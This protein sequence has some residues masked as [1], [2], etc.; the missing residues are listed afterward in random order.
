[1]H[2]RS[3]HYGGVSYIQL[4]EEVGLLYTVVGGSRVIVYS[5]SERQGHCIQLWEEG[6]LLYTFVVRGRVIVY[7]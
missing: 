2:H 4:E 3:M 6:R 7:R 5:C 1:M